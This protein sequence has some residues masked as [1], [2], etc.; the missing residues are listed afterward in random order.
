MNGVLLDASFTY[1]GQ[2]WRGRSRT[3]RL[4][5]LGQARPRS[6]AKTNRTRHSDGLRRPSPAGSSGCAGSTVPAGPDTHSF[7]VS[8]PLEKRRAHLPRRVGP[9]RHGSRR[10][11]SVRRFLLFEG[12]G[13]AGVGRTWDG[14][15]APS[16]CS[17]RQPRADLVSSPG[18]PAGRRPVGLTT[19]VGQQVGRGRRPIKASG[20]RGCGRGHTR[21]DS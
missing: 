20:C 6:T 13:P 1:A 8:W 17:V 2:R 7:P 12:C 16:P 15:L 11:R 14:A 18:P 4:V 5:Y 19:A 21:A 9:V 10:G 3:I